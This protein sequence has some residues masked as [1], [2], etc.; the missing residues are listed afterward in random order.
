MVLFI[1]N[2]EKTTIPLK[3]ILFYIV[4]SFINDIALKAVFRNEQLVEVLLRIFT[5]V[6]YSLFSLFFYLVVKSAII[7]KVIIGLSFV[8]FAITFYN[9]YN[10]PRASFD[11]IPVSVESIL[12][13]IYCL[14][15]FYERISEPQV[16][17]IYSSYHFWVIIGILIYLSGAFFLFTQAD[18]LSNQDKS[19]YW[20]IVYMTNILKNIFFS[21]A[22]YI[23]KNPTKNPL[24]KN[25]TI[26]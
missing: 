21:V 10:N 18:N 22:F 8:F 4:Y 14:Y 2:R 19:N 25:P 20:I 7:K 5:V 3:V 6:E 9:Y 23:K 24:R 11:S 13:I 12:I 15:Y 17:F 26:S 1:L 16:T